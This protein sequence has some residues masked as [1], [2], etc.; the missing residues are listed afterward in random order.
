MVASPLWSNHLAL[1]PGTRLGVYE[2]VAPLGA[3]GCS[4]TT[5]KPDLVSIGPQPG[6][7]WTSCAARALSIF[8][9]RI[10]VYAVPPAHPAGLESAPGKLMSGPTRKHCERGQNGAG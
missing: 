4:C 7:K 6:Q 5:W 1:T 2:I 9:A 10:D 8:P 3:G